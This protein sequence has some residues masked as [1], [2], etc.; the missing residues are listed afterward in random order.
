MTELDAV[1][2]LASDNTAGVFSLSGDTLAVLNF[3]LG[4]VQN[5]NVWRDFP[6]ELLT[7]AQIDQIVEL[8]DA[9]ADE[10]MR[11]V[12]MTPVG[13][14]MMWLE[15][16]PP[17]GW[18][19]CDGT[20]HLKA[21][22]P[23]LYALYG[24]RYG[25]SPDF[26]GVPDYSHR[27]P[28]GAVFEEE[29]DTVAGAETHTLTADQMPS[30]V[31]QVR[32]RNQVPAY[33]HSGTSGGNPSIADT[34]GTTNSTVLNTTTSAGGGLAHNNLHPIRYCWFIV[35]AGKVVDV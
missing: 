2:A 16:D 28:Y 11:E 5:L 19:I 3:A 22:Y 35:C 24:A 31:H 32:N 25:D 33:F 18:L 30:H 6:D 21:Q 15:P 26:F 4:I 13:A 9:A 12:K 29:L 20:G 1:V 7:D 34:A 14:I 23:E 27:S 8:I 10:I 17:P